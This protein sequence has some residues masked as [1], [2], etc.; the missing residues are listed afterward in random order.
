MRP[1]RLIGLLAWMAGAATVV[2]YAARAD[3]PVQV[4]IIE[5]LPKDWTWESPAIEPSD[6]YEA[7][8][9]GLVQLPSK[10]D[11]R[12]VKIDRKNP[13]A[14]HAQGVL[15]QPPGPC[16][17]MLRARDRAWLV[18]DGA[19]LAETNAITP[20]ASGHEDV[21]PILTPPDPGWHAVAP[22]EQERI[23]PWTS[24]GQAHRIELWGVIGERGTRHEP[25]D[26][27]VAI[28]AGGRVP[29][30]VGANRRIELTDADW[31][32][33]LGEE[34]DRLES[35]DT[36]RRR[37]AQ[38]AD[39]PYWRARHAFAREV[40]LKSHAAAAP[41]VGNL[42]DRRIRERLAAARRSPGARTAD[43]AFYRRMTLD[44]I[45]V[46]PDPAEVAAFLADPGPD[47]R[48]R[49]IE[50][51]LAD[52]RWA[53]A[54]MG[55]WQDVLAE[56]PGLIKPTLNNT[57]PFRSFLHDAFL[58][59]LSFDR[60]VT[61]L[62]RMDGSPM[63]GGPA[64]F[65]I[66]TQNDAPRAAK[67]HVLAKAFL[68]VD[69]KCARCHD[70]PSHP[71]DQ[72]DLFGLAGFLDGKPQ[73]IPATSTV[74]KQPGGREP[75]VS[76]SLHAGDNVV[77]SWN[78]TDIAPSTYPLPAHLAP[79]K[80]T[81]RER[82]AT[83]I[84]APRNTRFAQV[85]VNRMWKRYL[86]VGLIEPVDDWDDENAKPSHPE[87]LDDLARELMTHDYDLKAVARLILNSEAYQAQTDGDRSVPAASAEQRFF[88]GPARRR[89]SAEQIL[90]SLF[91]AAGK[92][93]RAEDLDVEPQGRR[94]PHEMLN[95]G[96]PRRAWELASTSN[97]RDRPS[98]SLPVVQSLVDVLQSFGWRPNRQDPISDRDDLVNPLQPA[99][100]A[101]GIAGN[102]IARLSD[103]SA[104]TELCL[105]EQPASELIRAVYLRVLSRVPDQREIDSLV[106]FIG[107][108]YAT[109][110]VPGAKANPVVPRG[111]RRV[112]W[113][114]HLSPEASQIQ[115]SEERAV[116][117]GDP[118]TT[119]LT[120]EFRE[121]MED[122]VWVLINSPEFV[123]IP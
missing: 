110:I 67:A 56:N 57:G 27:C 59:N 52:P 5:G 18:V 111:K 119:R 37:L 58:D 61:E 102:R 89:M 69:M 55:Y 113:S 66:A 43:A 22:G 82:L 123:F 11:R 122:V 23:I 60:F 38:Q 71:Y 54:W 45:G 51:R 14:V 41:R 120:R 33:F 72:A 15:V 80:E 7:P 112:S 47:K 70:A 74:P 6:A 63:G 103:D 91:A 68:A 76:V 34:R 84:T 26:L 115:V 77:P 12:G 98:L 29:I 8:A 116:R 16:H 39:A 1:F 114:N 95:L 108:T 104:I 75:A 83:L 10:Y 50:A 13:F 87:L 4:R 9:L 109:R 92:P 101:N 21:P 40:A 94:P 78:L 2:N 86:G 35:F 28:T 20:N 48:A 24:D 117:Q 93:F 46:I 99:I 73:T 32:S 105:K 42:I 65:G 49:A 30:L 36:G 53:D 62:I 90:D 118:P 64:G 97:E 44:T 19:A 17:L 96:N 121:R 106:A 25:G 100:I 79:R 81:T 107:D 3:E 31:A 85:I 88:A